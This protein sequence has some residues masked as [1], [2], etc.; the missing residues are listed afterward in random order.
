MYYNLQRPRQQRITYQVCNT[1][2][3][4]G[5]FFPWVLQFKQPNENSSGIV[6]HSRGFFVSLQRHSKNY[7]YGEN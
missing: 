7:E 1:S 3:V 5:K 6:I 2:P 4:L